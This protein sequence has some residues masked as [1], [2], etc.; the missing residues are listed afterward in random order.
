MLVKGPL[1]SKEMINFLPCS[2]GAMFMVFSHPLQHHGASDSGLGR[3][4]NDRSL[5][6]KLRAAFYGSRPCRNLRR[7]FQ[8]ASRRNGHRGSVHNIMESLAEL[9][10]GACDRQHSSRMSES[11]DRPQ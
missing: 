1:S 3:S 2:G 6:G 8:I 11:Y 7:I 4:A 10:R 9:L 5:S